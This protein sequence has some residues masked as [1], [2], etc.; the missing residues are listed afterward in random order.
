M[1]LYEDPLSPN[2]RRVRIFLAEKG[3]EVPGVQVNILP[4]ENLEPDHLKRNPNGLLPTLELDDGECISESAAICRYFEELH[5]E[6][7]LMGTSA[8]E[9]A[10]VDMWE[11]R[12]D[13][14]GMSAVAE[15]FR[16]K[17]PPYAERGIAGTQ[18]VKQ[19]PE[20]VERGRESVLRFYDFLEQRLS[21]SS[22]L[23]GDDLTSADIAAMC[24]IDFALFSEVEIP[25]K[26]GTLQAWFQQMEN[27]ESS[28]LNP[29]MVAAL[30]SLTKAL[31]G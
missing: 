2:C 9:K 21:E 6:P 29:G 11:R 8:L 15:N 5:P 24:A 30:G 3:I 4:G 27:R 10:D 28:K 16:N 18:D 14:E 26:C 17:F 7:R 25:Y 12:V 22:Y 20:L 31:S 13:F 19:I 1:K 23:A